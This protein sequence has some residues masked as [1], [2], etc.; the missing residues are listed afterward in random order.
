MNI[1]FIGTRQS[2]H[3]MR[4]FHALLAAGH[5]VALVDTCPEPLTEPVNYTRYQLPIGPAACTRFFSSLIPH[6]NADIVHCHWADELVNCCLNATAV[7]VVVSIWGSDVNQFVHLAPNG[8][9]RLDLS[10]GAQQFGYYQ[11]MRAFPRAAALIIDDPAMRRKCRFLAGDEPP[12]HFNPLGVD[13]HFF[14]P[15][16]VGIRHEIRQRLGVGERT[17]LFLSP[18]AVTPNYRHDDILRAF[19]TLG[20][21]DAVLCIKLFNPRALFMPL[22][23]SPQELIDKGTFLRPGEKESIVEMER[24]L[25]SL[26]QTLHI[27]DRVR[28]IGSPADELLPAVYAASDVIV[29]FPR[30]D[31]FPVLFAEA[32]ACGKRVITNDLPAYRGTFAERCF[33][34]LPEDSV[35]ALTAA[36]RHALSTPPSEERL[37]EAR[38]AVVTEYSFSHY[39]QRLQ[40]LY[41]HILRDVSQQPSQEKSA[42]P[43]PAISFIIPCYNYE[44]FLP[45]CLA[46]LQAQTCGDW[47]A[48]VV[49]DCSPADT[50]RDMVAAL[51]DARIRCVRHETNRG[52]GAA[53]NTG[54]L[55]SRGT[56]ISLLS[57][58]DKLAPGFC[59]RCLDAAE[60]PE[61]YESNYHGLNIRNKRPP[62]LVFCDLQLFGQHNE[63]WS[64]RMF[65]L[66]KLT[67]RQWIPGAG[68]ILQREYYRYAHGHYE[69]PE[70]RYGNIDWEFWLAVFRDVALHVVH[71]PAPLYRYRS[72][73]SSITDRRPYVDYITRQCLYRRHAAMF[74]S[75]DTQREFL[76]EGY[77]V[78]ALAAWNRGEYL[79]AALLSLEAAN[80]Q[81]VPPA[82]EGYP[83]IPDGECGRQRARLLLALNNVDHRQAPTQEENDQLVLLARLEMQ[84]KKYVL[85]EHHLLIALGQ[86]VG[87]HALRRIHQA[88]TLLLALSLPQDQSEDSRQLANF[89]LD[90]FP[91]HSHSCYL[92][93]M[94]ALEKQRTAEAFFKAASLMRHAP[95]RSSL[96]VLGHICRQ[97]VQQ[98]DGRGFVRLVRYSASL[99]TAD[100]APVKTDLAWPYHTEFGR[101]LYWTHR[102]RDLFA[103]YGHK[104]GGIEEIFRAIEA[105]TPATVLDFGCGN[106]RLL[107]PLRRRYPHIQL[108][109]Q[110]ISEEA[111]DLARKRNMEQV[112]LFACPLSELPFAAKYFD[113]IICTRV[114][115]H[116]PPAQIGTIIQ[117]LVHLGRAVYINEIMELEKASD[118]CFAHDYD[119]IFGQAG[120]ERK[121]TQEVPHGLA[122]VYAPEGQGLAP[123]A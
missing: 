74:H 3:C 16:A 112:R 117:E 58:D 40:A 32:G 116:I 46:S 50:A 24:T 13:S 97:I 86:A 34:L 123:Q 44:H 48:I 68:F 30:I 91:G 54:Y 28:F 63:T 29:N 120:Y 15:V 103:D 105:T 87:W 66:E 113:L 20:D 96:L 79:R 94:Q 21:V 9:I 61:R 19:A 43:V 73:G 119:R 93:A 60:H 115:Q 82:D 122:I 25:R 78:S 65:N 56:Y 85:A 31:G 18:R 17:T 121:M 72:H 70:L 36:M 102:A 84:T 14:E 45:E 81:P 2:P 80:Q 51:H 98:P 109:G 77:A 53:F 110:D 23:T 106:G 90:I 83:R 75:F 26:A 37:A 49:D 39:M 64:Y 71:I 89:L 55:H 57:S 22:P 95:L 107:L 33:D 27:E 1:L 88:G 111:L 100:A 108:V 99:P 11:L 6:F 7:P 52:A 59:E 4:P 10:S 12:I 38:Q 47:E 42:P 62:N 114:L 118:Y 8:E 101:K 41:T 76:G 92:L 69:G 104:D 35:Q 67:R 5:T